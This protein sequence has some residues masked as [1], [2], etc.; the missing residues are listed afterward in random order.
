MAH[1]IKGKGVDF[2]END[3]KWHYGGLDSDTLAKAKQYVATAV[4]E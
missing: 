1:T 2:M 3:V 4:A